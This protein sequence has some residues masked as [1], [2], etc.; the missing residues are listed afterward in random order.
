ME[1][2]ALVL[3]PVVDQVDVLSG[4][5]GILRE[6]QRIMAAVADSGGPVKEVDYT[7]RFL[8]F[9]IGRPFC[10]GEGRRRRE[11]MGAKKFLGRTFLQKRPPQTPPQKLL[12]GWR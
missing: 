8:L 10:E 7:V 11:G 6:G 5:E 2:P 1:Q 9:D 12:N 4:H 3:R